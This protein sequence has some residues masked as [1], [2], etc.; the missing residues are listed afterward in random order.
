MD[1]LRKVTSSSTVNDL[2]KHCVTA[3]QRQFFQALGLC[4]GN[5]RWA[6]DRKTML[7]EARKEEEETCEIIVKSKPIAGNKSENKVC[8]CYAFNAYLHI[9]CGIC[10]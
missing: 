6:D 4:V 7:E 1:P 2:I 9:M 8:M 5:E 3:E 10:T